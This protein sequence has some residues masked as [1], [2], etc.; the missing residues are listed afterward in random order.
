MRVIMKLPK[1][2]RTTVPGFTAGVLGAS[3]VFWLHAPQSSRAQEPPPSIVMAT[4]YRVVDD[5][6]QVRTVL[7]PDGIAV[8]DEFQRPRLQLRGDTPGLY[9]FD[10]QGQ[11]RAELFLYPGGESHLYL[12]DREHF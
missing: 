10:E 3:L 7:N 6:G 11:T 2:L 4:E 8:F 5:R 1:I 12:H 9:I